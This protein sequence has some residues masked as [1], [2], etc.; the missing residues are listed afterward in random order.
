MTYIDYFLKRT[1]GGCHAFQVIVQRNAE[2]KFAL[3]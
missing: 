2:K 1:T 3:Y